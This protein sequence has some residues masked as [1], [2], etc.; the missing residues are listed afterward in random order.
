MSEQDPSMNLHMNGG[1]FEATPENTSLFLFAGQ[2][3]MY[4]HV[5][6]RLEDRDENTVSGTYVF[7]THQVYERMRDYMLQQGYPAHVNLRDIAQC[8]LDAYEQMIAQQIGDISDTIPE[9]WT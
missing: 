5:F 6:I 9:E 8:D 3:S 2:L 4:N 7:S 1:D